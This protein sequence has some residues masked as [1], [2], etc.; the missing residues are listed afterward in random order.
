MQPAGDG[1][2]ALLQGEERVPDYFGGGPGREHGGV[3][4]A[5]RDFGE[6]VGY[7]PDDGEAAEDLEERG[8]YWGGNDA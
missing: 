8:K 5:D 7:A 1:E 6:G 4:R 2:A 3:K